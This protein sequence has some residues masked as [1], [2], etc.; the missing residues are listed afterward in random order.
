MALLFYGHVD[1]S[2][3]PTLTLPIT[4]T[5]S[6]SPLSPPPPASFG[7]WERLRVHGSVNRSANHRL[8]H[9]D[10]Q[11]STSGAARRGVAWRTPESFAVMRSG[12][13]LAWN[14]GS[15]KVN[16]MCVESGRC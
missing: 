11:R 5:L 9:A 7:S 16:P 1:D 10:I 13:N 8:P 15:V 14:S 2:D 6:P 12:G 4:T 3:T